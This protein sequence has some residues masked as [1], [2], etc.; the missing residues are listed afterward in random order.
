MTIFIKCH[1]LY[2]NK[3][4]GEQFFLEKKTLNAFLFKERVKID[5]KRYNAYALLVSTSKLPVCRLV[6][7]NVTASDRRPI[8]EDRRL[9]NTK[10]LQRDSGW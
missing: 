8:V 7:C 9:S 4:K 5:K 1:R 2:V 6:C 3:K 10:G